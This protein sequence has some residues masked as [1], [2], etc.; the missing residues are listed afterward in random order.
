MARPETNWSCC[1]FRL[2]VTRPANRRLTSQANV[3]VSSL[4]DADTRRCRSKLAED[5]ASE[6]TLSTIPRPIPRCIESP[7]HSATLTP[8]V[9]RLIKTYSGPENETAT[10]PNF[11]RQYTVTADLAGR[12]HV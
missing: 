5:F 1:S 11:P 2:A 7:L 3:L 12:R 9:Y 8:V 6:T 10:G 4:A